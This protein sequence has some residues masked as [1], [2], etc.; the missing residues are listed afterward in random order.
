VKTT[1]VPSTVQIH[2]RLAGVP[3]SEFRVPETM[4]PIWVARKAPP[5]S[6]AS[7]NAHPTR[8]PSPGWML[9]LT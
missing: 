6:R 9:L 7:S 5:M 1:I 8:N 2:H 4:I 3:N